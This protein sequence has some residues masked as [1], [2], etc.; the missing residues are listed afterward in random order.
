MAQ[1][2]AM[3]EGITNRPECAELAALAA[4]CLKG[5]AKTG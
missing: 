1:Q 3:S 4:L 2:S 5:R